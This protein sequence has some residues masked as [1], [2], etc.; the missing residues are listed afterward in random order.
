MQ[1]TSKPEQPTKRGWSWSVK[2]MRKGGGERRLFKR[3]SFV[4]K[5]AATNRA[6][7]A[8]PVTIRAKVSKRCCE[9]RVAFFLYYILIPQSA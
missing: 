7:S 9:I 6:S 2:S 1:P 4:M 8:A 3:A 5:R